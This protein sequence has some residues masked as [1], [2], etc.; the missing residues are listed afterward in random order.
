MKIITIKGG[1]GN[2]LFQYAYGRNL[3]L[4]GKKIV[5]DVSFF[6]GN[7]AK[8]DT[9]RDFKLNNY[10]IETKAEF[11]NKKN[12]VSNTFNKIKR[13]LG[14][15]VEE[16]YQ[17]EKYF[18]NIKGE[19]IKELTLKNPLSKDGQIW[20]NKINNTEN[21]VSIHIRRGDY[22]KNQKM[23][24]YYG[25][26]NIEYYKNGLAKILE[27]DTKKNIIVFVFSDDI[28]WVKKNLNLPYP[29][30]F[31]SNSVIP[32]PEEIFLM[33]LCKNNII[34]NSSFS[35]WGA[36]LNKNINKIVIAPKQWTSVET[37]DELD[38]LPK[39]WVKI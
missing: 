17:S 8:T 6:N 11:L 38:I 36:W 13:K 21:S 34:A 1:L 25:T 31:V 24:S 33:S 29:V 39:E 3:E 23:N 28:D 35:W 20:Q 19:I 14:L 32:D 7:K 30:Y 5:F 26:C 12:F 4:S 27:K 37:S 10:N 18:K 9:A 15:K 2:Q 22:V 16:Y